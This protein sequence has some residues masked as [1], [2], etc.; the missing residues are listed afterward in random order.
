[1]DQIAAAEIGRRTQ[2]GSLELALESAEA[3]TCDVGFSCAYTNTIS[4]RSPTT[5]LPM[6]HNPRA[7]FERLFGDSGS[8]D[9]AA[10]LERLRSN[11]SVLDSVNEKVARLERSLGSRD[12]TQ[13]REYMDAIRDVERRIQLAEQSGRNELPPMEQPVGVPASFEEHARLMFDL[14]VLAYQSDLTRVITF[15]VGREFSGRSYPEVGAPDAHHPTSHHQ[16]DPAKLEQLTKINTFHAR[17]FA[18]FLDKL[19]ATRDGDGSLLDHVTIIYGAGMSDGNAHSPANL[20][21]ILAGGGAGRLQGGRHL[22]Y[23][24]ETPLANLHVTLL[25]MIDVKVERFA[26]STGPLPELSL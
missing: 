1:M 4:W 6:E 23:A 21:I 3:G 24:P 2:L 17:Q 14:Q 7:V 9:P 16:G 25:D 13:L 11:R 20:P 19:R 18:Y 26:G 10:R 12:Q 5:P 22:R 15:M 8:T